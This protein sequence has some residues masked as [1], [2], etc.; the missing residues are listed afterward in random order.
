LV[1]RSIDAILLTTG[2]IRSDFIKIDYLNNALKS[3]EK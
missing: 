3:K 2:F 1:P